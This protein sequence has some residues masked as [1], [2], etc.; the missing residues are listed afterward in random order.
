MKKLNNHFSQFSFLDMILLHHCAKQA[1]C[2][3]MIITIGK[4]LSGLKYANKTGVL[5]D[6]IFIPARYF[7][8]LSILANIDLYH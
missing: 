6:D 1:I 8:L 5:T 4:T 3:Q 2:T 7:S